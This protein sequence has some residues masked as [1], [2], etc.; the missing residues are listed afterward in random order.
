MNMGIVV[1]VNWAT[2]LNMAVPRTPSTPLKSPTMSQIP[3][4]PEPARANAIGTP[5]RS[6]NTSMITRRAKV[7]LH[8]LSTR[9]RRNRLRSS[10]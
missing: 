6:S 4:M 2:V 5:T 7:I 10:Y 1:R 9:I 8:V 3:S